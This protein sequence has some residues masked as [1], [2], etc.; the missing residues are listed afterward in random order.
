MRLPAVRE[1]AVD[2]RC[3]TIDCDDKALTHADADF[4]H[5]LEP[6]VAIEF[7]AEC[8]GLMHEGRAPRRRELSDVRQAGDELAA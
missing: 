5:A 2:Q 6:Q 8:I 3:I 7:T 1:P 4:A